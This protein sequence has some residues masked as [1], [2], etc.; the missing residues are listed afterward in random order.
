MC[1]FLSFNIYVKFF[2]SFL[3]IFLYLWALLFPLP[4]N[5]SYLHLFLLQDKTTRPMSLPVCSL[6]RN[7]HLEAVQKFSHLYLHKALFVLFF[8]STFFSFVEFT[9]EVTDTQMPLVAPVILP[10]MYKIFTMAEVWN[11]SS[12]ITANKS[13]SGSGQPPHHMWETVVFAASPRTWRPELTEVWIWINLRSF[14]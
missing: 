11:L 7:C 14:T 10:E 13:C 12:K 4:T 5:N 8:Y 1:L 6:L 2:S 9:R 3:C